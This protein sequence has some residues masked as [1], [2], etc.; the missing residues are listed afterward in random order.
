MRKK[1][2]YIVLISLA[3][4]SCSKNNDNYSTTLYSEID[5]T[6][7]GT[8]DTIQSENNLSEAEAYL[9]AEKKLKS[10]VL[11]KFHSIINLDVSESYIED[12]TTPVKKYIT[13]KNGNKIETEEYKSGN[14][15]AEHFE[16][17]NEY[18]DCY[19]VTIIGNASGYTD[20]YDD[21]FNKMTFTFKV[22]IIKSDGNTTDTDF[23]FSMEY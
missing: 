9:I 4:S 15:Y 13:D 14:I 8:S 7:S 3:I 17:K 1:F 23:N 6:I 22:S 18:V 16:T 10:C 12:G 2:F 11:N 5:N 21:D 20:T 19:F